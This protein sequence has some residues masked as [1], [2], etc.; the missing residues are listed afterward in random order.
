MSKLFTGKCTY[1]CSFLL[2]QAASQRN[3][4]NC[5]MRILG[6]LA[7]IMRFSA[8]R[9]CLHDGQSHAASPDIFSVSKNNLRQS[10]R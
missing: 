4:L 3:L 5:T 9:F 2:C 7:M 8:L 6:S 1:V 10:W